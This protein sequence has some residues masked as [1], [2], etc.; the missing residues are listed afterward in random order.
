MGMGY[1]ISTYVVENFLTTGCR[2]RLV[3]RGQL[4]ASIALF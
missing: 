4:P 2:R 1:G 3:G